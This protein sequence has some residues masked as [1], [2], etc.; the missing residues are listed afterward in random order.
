M[1]EVEQHVEVAA[2]ERP[3]ERAAR[4]RPQDLAG[5]RDLLGAGRRRAGRGP[6]REDGAAARRVAA[7]GDVVRPPQLDA[8]D[9]RIVALVARVLVA[10]DR[11]VR[12][13]HALEHRRLV[14]EGHRE[15]VGTGGDREAHL[16]AVVGRVPVVAPLLG[17]RRVE[18]GAAH[19]ERLHE[20]AVE[21]HL[22]LVPVG[23]A[24][25]PPVVGAREVDLDDVLAVHGEG[26]PHRQPAA[27]AERQVVAD[28]GVLLQ[29]LVDGEDLGRR[30]E[31]RVA[32]REPADLPRR[33]QVALGQHGRHRQHVGDVVEAEARVVGRQQ[34]P[35]VDVEGEQVADGVGV[36]GAVQTVDGGAPARVRVG[37]RGGVDRRLEAGDD[38][39]VLFLARTR[40]ARRGHRAGAELPDHPLPQVHLAGVLAD[41]VEVD[42]LQGDAR[43]QGAVVVAAHAVA[44]EEGAVVRRGLRQGNAPRKRQHRRGQNRRE[45]PST[46]LTVWHVQPLMKLSQK[47]AAA[48][49]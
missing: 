39:L 9:A 41:P 47:P 7:A 28:P 16:L 43:G 5:A 38:P 18:D 19:G 11:V 32:H 15:Q 3:A 42:A 26:V 8:A 1:E 25:Q 35:G 29:V 13:A 4:E 22:H 48:L 21:P 14:D 17:P 37:R 44:R 12:P 34:R 45:T 6:T 36:L 49:S 24:A 30:G 10:R 27:R 33:R 46:H 31:V 40:P 20:G 23:E 2:V